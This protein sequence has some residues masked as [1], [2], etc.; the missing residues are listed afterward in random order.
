MPVSM[1]AVKPMF[2][3]S[4]Q[5]RLL[6]PLADDDT[7]LWGT[8]DSLESPVVSVKDGKVPK[9]LPCAIFVVS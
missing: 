8:E 6:L 1:Q 9:R 2:A 5:S 4:A 3:S 7:P